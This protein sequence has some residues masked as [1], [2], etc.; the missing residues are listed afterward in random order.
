MMP[1]A[2]GLRVAL[3]HAWI[4]ADSQSERMDAAFQGVLELDPAN[5]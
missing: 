3:S 4:A 2:L 5:D 1:T